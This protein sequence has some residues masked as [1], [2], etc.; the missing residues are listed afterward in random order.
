MRCMAKVAY[1]TLLE[2]NGWEN[3]AMQ[4]DGNFERTKAAI[5]IIN[6]GFGGGF[7]AGFI[8]QRRPNY[9]A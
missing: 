7:A 5:R 4:H 9:R 3:G 6:C 2:S 1:A 8:G